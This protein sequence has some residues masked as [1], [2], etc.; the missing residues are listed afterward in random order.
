MSYTP[1]AG[2]GRNGQLTVYGDTQES[3]NSRRRAIFKE[4]YDRLTLTEGRWGSEVERMMWVAGATEESVRT[5]EDQDHQFEEEDR[6][7]AQEVDELVIERDVLMSN[8]TNEFTEDPES[9]DDRRAHILSRFDKGSREMH[10][11]DESE[12]LSWVNRET[13][14]VVRMFREKDRQK[15]EG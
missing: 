3:R 9:Q 14:D 8:N 1:S 2:S 7:A 11:K 10:W 15:R 12:R 13:D 5:L 4:R 6:I